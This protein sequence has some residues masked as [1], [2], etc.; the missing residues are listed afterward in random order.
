MLRNTDLS[1]LLHLF[2]A[3]IHSLGTISLCPYTVGLSRGVNDSYAKQTA[4]GPYSFL[5]T[6]VIIFAAPLQSAFTKQLLPLLYKP[7]CLDAV[8]H[9]GNP[10][11]RRCIALFFSVTV[12][13]H[14]LSHHK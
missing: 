2:L 1:V 13:N 7:R 4:V 14:W 6:F 8:A 5:L 12:S 10:L 3:E 9:G 11:W